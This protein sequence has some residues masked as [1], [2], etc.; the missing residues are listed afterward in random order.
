MKYL[1]LPLLI[2]S[3]CTVR[4]PQYATKDKRIITKDVLSTGDTLY[5]DGWANLYIIRLGGK[6]TT[7]M[8]KEDDKDKK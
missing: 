1:L 5:C 7:W 6:D 8:M 3:A 2:F 4:K